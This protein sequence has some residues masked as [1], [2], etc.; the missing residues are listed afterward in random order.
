MSNETQ[1]EAQEALLK[2]MDAAELANHVTHKQLLPRRRLA[3]TKGN[4]PW[5]SLSVAVFFIDQLSKGWVSQ[6]IEMGNPLT[7]NAFINIV[8]AYNPGAAFSI[9]ADAGGWQ[10]WFFIIL[11]SIVCMVL[12]VWIVKMRRGHHTVALAL[13]LIL[14]GAAGNLW[15]RIEFGYVI[16]FIDVYYQQYHWPAFNVADAAITLGAVILLLDALF[17]HPEQ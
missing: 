1:D 4:Y 9:L 16:D 8:L 17:A 6:N 7:V 14:G 3:K 5:L 15:D 11:A 2:K 12:I 10:R 13:A